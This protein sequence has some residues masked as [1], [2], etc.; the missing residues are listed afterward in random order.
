MQTL[1]TLISLGKCPGLSEPLLD[2]QVI[3][4]FCHEVAHLI[5]GGLEY[6]Y[7]YTS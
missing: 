1:K 7:H 3:L 6:S 2:A 5:W 4:L